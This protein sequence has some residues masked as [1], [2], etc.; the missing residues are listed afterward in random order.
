MEERPQRPVA[1]ARVVVA[2]PSLLVVDPCEL[3]GTL[4]V[5]GSVALVDDAGRGLRRRRRATTP[6]EPHPTARPERGLERGDKPAN[7]LLSFAF[8]SFDMA[9]VRQAVR[10]DE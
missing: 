8:V 1:E 2:I 10:D 3:H 6:S 7:G 5:L 4:R 9:K